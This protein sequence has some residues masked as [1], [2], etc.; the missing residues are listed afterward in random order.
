MVEVKICGTCRPEDA[1][2]ASEAG[3]TWVGV[4]L[5][6][7]R[8]RTRTIDEAA[9]IF[10]ASRARRVGV[11]V[12][13]PAQAVIDAAGELKLDA[14]QLH[15]DESIDDVRRIRD[16]VACEIWKA[17]R[18]RKADDLERG[19]EVYGGAGAGVDAIL[20]DGWSPDAHGGAGV[21]VDWEAVAQAGMSRTHFRL[22]VAG[23]LTPRNVG[24]AVAL[25]RPDVVDVSSGVEVAP[26]RKSSEMINSFVAAARG[27]GGRE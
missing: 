1:R 12:D 7:G 13:S 23:G 4:I 18:V 25:L 21:R 27:N 20:V 9:G 11:F 6:P 5:A 2:A 16:G 17:I 8:T 24:A 26:G 3:A 22:I 19:V 15:G 10:A 14:V